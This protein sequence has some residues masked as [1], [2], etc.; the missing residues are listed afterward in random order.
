MELQLCFPGLAL[1]GGHC[2]HTT[3]T[4]FGR[5]IFIIHNEDSMPAL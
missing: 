4:A 5:G 3:Y 2:L 1:V